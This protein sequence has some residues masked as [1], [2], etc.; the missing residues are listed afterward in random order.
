MAAR[1]SLAAVLVVLAASSVAAV[2]ALSDEGLRS[3]DP[4]ARRD[5]VMRLAASGDTAAAT[6]IA[7]LLNDP[8]ESVRAAAAGALGRLHDVASV[9]ALARVAGA[10][11]RPFV[12]KTAASA[13]G[14]IGDRA[15]VPALVE[16]V[17]RER[18]SEVRAAAVIALGAIGD[19]SATAAL[20]E[21]LSDGDAFVRREAV[22]ALGRVGAAEALP[23]IVARLREDREAEVRRRAAEALGA[24]GDERARE[25]LRE[26]VQDADPYVADAAV[27]A[28]GV[29]DRARGGGGGSR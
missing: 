28:L 1:A 4:E 19:P 9:G 15:G 12:R 20:R 26:A 27:A 14:E 29:L 17:R 2:Q 7:P 3:A 18:D 6:L 21:R 16:R 25:A 23:D 10:D 5:A 11:K 24:L 13:L 8:T 22:R